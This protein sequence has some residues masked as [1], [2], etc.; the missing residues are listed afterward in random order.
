MLKALVWDVDHLPE[1]VKAIRAMLTADYN[2]SVAVYVH[3][4]AGCDRTGEVMGAY[5]LQ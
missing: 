3:C 2:S 4:T 5:M 1:R